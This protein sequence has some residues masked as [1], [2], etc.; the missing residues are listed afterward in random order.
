MSIK[1][2]EPV[3]GNGNHGQPT[4]EPR[5]LHGRSFRS[6]DGVVVSLVNHSLRRKARRL[7]RNGSSTERFSVLLVEAPRW[8]GVHALLSKRL[9]TSGIRVLDSHCYHSRRR[10]FVFF[11][12]SKDARAFEALQSP[13]LKGELA[14]EAAAELRAA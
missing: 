2:F 3:G 1:Q 14:A 9:A 10:S 13:T 5:W 7:G 11:R 8:P 12:T 4:S 6:R